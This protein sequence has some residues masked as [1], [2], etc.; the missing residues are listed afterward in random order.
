MPQLKG[1]I[2]NISVTSDRLQNPPS[3]LHFA[4]LYMYMY[5]KG[6]FDTKSRVTEGFISCTPS[7]IKWLYTVPY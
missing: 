6:E 1:C 2:K 7:V 4:F 5:N 3:K